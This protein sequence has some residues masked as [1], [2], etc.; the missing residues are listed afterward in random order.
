MVLMGL[1]S[2]FEDWDNPNYTAF[3]YCDLTFVE[4]TKY[5]HY[6]DET[7]VLVYLNSNFLLEKI[8]F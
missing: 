3:E 2:H 8:V 4:L 6:F 7:R 5:F 1:V